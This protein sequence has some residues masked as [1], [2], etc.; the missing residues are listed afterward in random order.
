MLGIAIVIGNTK[1]GRNGEADRREAEPPRIAS[2]ACRYKASH[3]CGDFVRSRIQG[4]VAGLENVN[5]SVRHVLAI[6]FR[7]T[8][9]EGEIVLTPDHHEPRLLLAHP[10]LPFR[11]CVYICPIAAT[12][13]LCAAR[14]RWLRDQPK[15]RVAVSNW[16]RALRYF[17][18]DVMESVP[19]AVAT[20]SQLI[21]RIEFARTLHGRYRSRF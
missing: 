3:Q 13:D 9:I 16:R 5:L 10:R 19:R 17:V 11:I 20:G 14:F 7:F 21:A 1:S 15:K 12:A 2:A 4:K 6:A 18:V 8:E